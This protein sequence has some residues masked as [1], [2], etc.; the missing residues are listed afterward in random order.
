MGAGIAA[1]PAPT[2][3]HIN[4]H[5]CKIMVLVQEQQGNHMV[6]MTMRFS[7]GPHFFEKGACAFFCG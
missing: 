2:A 5:A 7:C 1:I 6:K 4:P 3:K